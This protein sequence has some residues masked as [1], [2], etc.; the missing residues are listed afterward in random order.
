[1]KDDKTLE[2]LLDLDG[3]KMVIDEKLGLWVK[4]EASVTSLSIRSN[5]IRYSLSLHDQ[6]GR[7]IIGFDN[8]HKIEYGAKR[9]VAP[10]RTFDHWH[11]NEH[12]EGRP[13]HYVN[14]GK[15]M[16]DFWLEVEKRLTLLKKDEK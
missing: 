11:F 2:N 5:G 1:M 12:D 15:L 4:F 3:I 16:E 7:R 10:K 8:A 6:H 13:Y 14:A 9:M